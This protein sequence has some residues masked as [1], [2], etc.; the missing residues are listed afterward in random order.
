M[1]TLPLILAGAML[2]STG[3]AF[4]ESR[5][6][7]EA[8]DNT[9]VIVQSGNDNALRLEQRGSDHTAILTQNGDDNRLKLK[10]FGDGEVAV[11]T[12][13]GGEHATVIQGSN[14]NGNPRRVG[15]QR[16]LD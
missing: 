1:K 11:I 14:G 9:A 7:R 6:S 15:Q 2:A 3:P 10:Q 8:R 13:N 16:H 5:A 4:A 12:Q